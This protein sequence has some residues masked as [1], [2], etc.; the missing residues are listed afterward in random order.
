MRRKTHLPSCREILIKLG[1]NILKN[2]TAYFR[3][4]KEL[5]RNLSFLSKVCLWGHRTFM[6]KGISSIKL[7][8]IIHIMVQSSILKLIAKNLWV[9]LIHLI[10]ASISPHLQTNTTTLS[11]SKSPQLMISNWPYPLSIERLHNFK[12]FNDLANI[13]KMNSI[14]LQL[15]PSLMK[16]CSPLNPYQQ[17]E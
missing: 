1:N 9:G 3:A 16:R 14:V 17:K 8:T 10:S 11:S 7:Q 12:R 6:K 15:N 5:S 4:K 13:M 2:R